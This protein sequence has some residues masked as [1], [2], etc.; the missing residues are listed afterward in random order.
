[1]QSVF[2]YAEVTSE[3]LRTVTDLF[4]SRKISPR[5]GTVLPLAEARTAHRMLAGAP[6][7]SGKI[8]L[9]ILS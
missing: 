3:R 6:H 4:E 8:V 7:E 2:F 9:E 5:V 1:M